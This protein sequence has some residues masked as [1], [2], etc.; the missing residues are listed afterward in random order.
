MLHVRFAVESGCEDT[1]FPRDHFVVIIIL[2]M[3]IAKK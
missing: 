1:D 2:Y 3:Y